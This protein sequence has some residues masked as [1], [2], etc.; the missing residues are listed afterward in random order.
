MKMLR[1]TIPT[2]IDINAKIVIGD[3]KPKTIF[4]AKD[5]ERFCEEIK[6]IECEEKKR[7]L[8][9]LIQ[10]LEVGAKVKLEPNGDIKLFFKFDKMIKNQ[11]E[12]VITENDELYSLVEKLAKS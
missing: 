7:E 4:K 11:P 10:C 9:D 12:G 1:W 2:K 8:F 3:N 5:I 6:R